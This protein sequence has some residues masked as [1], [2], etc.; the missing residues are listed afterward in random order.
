MYASL[1]PDGNAPHRFPR[2]MR[3][4]ALGKLPQAYC[5]YDLTLGR[6]LHVLRL[7]SHC[8]AVPCATGDALFLPVMP[9]RKST[10]QVLLLEEKVV[11]DL[12][13]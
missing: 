10:C 5:D 1:V 2:P 8:L 3:P 7:R 6:C 13:R 4:L 9:K 12:W 11:L